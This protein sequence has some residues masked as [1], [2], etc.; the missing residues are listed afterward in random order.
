MAFVL[1][2]RVD[3][4]E[5]QRIQ[6]VR[7]L[8]IELLHRVEVEPAAE[9]RDPG[10]EIIPAAR[11]GVPVEAVALERKDVAFLLAGQK[12][13]E[14]LVGSEQLLRLLDLQRLGVRQRRIIREF[15][16]QLRVMVGELA[17]GVGH[18]L[19]DGVDLRRIRPIRLR[20]RLDQRLVA[21]AP[22]GEQVLVLAHERGERVVA[23][24]E[25]WAQLLDGGGGRRLVRPLCDLERLAA[26]CR[27]GVDARPRR[28]R[29]AGDVIDEVSAALLDQAA[30]F[31]RLPSAG[32]AERGMREHGLAGACANS[33]LRWPDRRARRSACARSLRTRATSGM[34]LAA[35]RLIDR[36][37]PLVGLLG[38]GVA[39]LVLEQMALVDQHRGE[40][41]VVR[42]ERL[43][44]DVERP[45]E[46]RL[47]LGRAT[48]PVI[49]DAELAD[50]LGGVGIVRA[51]RLLRRSRAPAWS[52]FSTS[53]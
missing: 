52:T 46:L 16:L 43:G 4:T 24:A 34:V 32:V 36:Q 33:R 7:D 25:A 17:L 40:I 20:Q 39:A 19:A 29:Q 27:R 42:A 41:A 22:K 49:G 5:E 48:L 6:P 26:E 31:A 47:R 51:E 12:E 15:L 45:L 1:D 8:E 38:V 3:R 13:D 14:R 30:A 23:G 11:N 28:R 53:S 9:G 35:R 50:D 37:R 44:V 18:L 21:V 10:D 2:E